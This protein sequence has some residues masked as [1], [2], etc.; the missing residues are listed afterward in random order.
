M[1]LYGNRSSRIK[2][3]K[4]ERCHLRQCVESLCRIETEGEGYV[5]LMETRTN[6]TYSAQFNRI[7]AGGIHIHNS[8]KM[9]MM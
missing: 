3:D 8:F 9:E 7:C 2:L 5:V 6:T 4:V 1:E